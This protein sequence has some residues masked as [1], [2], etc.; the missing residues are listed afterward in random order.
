[1]AGYGLSVII[2]LIGFYVSRHYKHLAHQWQTRH[3]T[4]A[5]A[6]ETTGTLQ[7]ILMPFKDSL[8]E[9]K[10]TM[11]RMQQ[12]DQ[13]IQASLTGEIKQLV[14]LNQTLATEAKQLTQALKGDPKMQGNWGELILETVLERA[15]L[16]KGLEFDTQKSMKNPD[17]RHQQPD[18]VL[19]LPDNKYLIIDAKVS[20]R[21]YERYC[22][23]TSDSDKRQALKAHITAVKKHI[24]NLSSK[25]YGDLATTPD[26][27]LAFM[28]I[29]PAFNLAIQMDP[30][31]C[32]TAIDKRV[33]IVSTS[34]LLATVQ[35]VATVWQQTRQTK[36]ARLIAQQGGALYDK[37]AL[38]LND[39]NRIGS[40]LTA[41]QDLYAAV[42]HKLT[43]GPGNLAK[44]MKDLEQLGIKTSKSLPDEVGL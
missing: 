7:G 3:D 4:I 25:N 40:Q 26:F 36:H 1:M 8:T 12:Q 22:S 17:G 43:V 35:L 18:V 19:N 37:F 10:Q 13:Y 31:L 2:G 28:P 24:E 14:Q 41:I 30:D 15:G 29:E 32:Y 9:F 20:L 5:S 33:I 42:H 23:A 44:R 38:F 21:A 39:F 16:K 27:V 6:R 11:E 34:T